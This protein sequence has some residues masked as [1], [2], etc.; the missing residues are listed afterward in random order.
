MN[1]LTGQVLNNTLAIGDTDDQIWLPSRNLTSL[2]GSDLQDQILQVRTS[3]SNTIATVAKISDDNTPLQVSGVSATESPFRTADG[4]LKSNVGVSFI[5]NPSDTFF[6]HVQIWFTGY[7]GNALPQL[8]PGDTRVSPASFLCDTTHETVTVTVVAVSSTGDTADFDTAPTT[9]VVLDGVTSAPSAPSIAQSLVATPTGY[10]FSFNQLGGLSADQVDGYQVWRNT[11]NNSSTAARFQYFK[12][13]PINSTPV[14]VTDVAP[15]G[16]VY[17]YWVSSVNTTG[18]ESSKTAVQSQQVGSGSVIGPDGNPHV[19]TGNLVYNPNFAIY[20][21]PTGLIDPFASSAR[22]DEID[23]SGNPEPS[24]NGWT[25]NFESSGNGEG[26]C[27]RIQQSTFFGAGSWSLV[28]Q[29]RQSSVNDCFASVSDAFP[30]IPGKKYRF[31][32]QVN[33]G[34][35][36][37][38]P[39]H[40]RWYFRVVFYKNL[41]TDFS[42]T[43]T[44]ISALTP[45]GIG[46]GAGF[47]SGGFTG[48]YDIA[49]GSALSGNQSPADTVTVPTDAA[50]ARI[51]FYHWNDGTATASVW[52][53]V[54]AAVQC[55]ALTV[56][57]DAAFNVSTVLNGQGSILPNQTITFTKAAETTSTLGWSWG[58]QTFLRPDSSTFTLGSGSQGFTGL[59]SNH[60]YFFYPYLTNFQT[61]TASMNF[62]MS[63]S[64]DTTQAQNAQFDGRIGMGVISDSTTATGTGGGGS[65]DPGGAC[66]HQDE[67]VWVGEGTEIPAKD[68]RDSHYIKGYS[69]AQKKDVYRR[70]VTIRHQP[71]TFWYRVNGHLVSPCEVVWWDNAWVPAY[72]VPGAERVRGVPADRIEIRVEADEFDER[73]YYL[74]GEKPLLIHNFIIERS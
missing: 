23:S 59:T 48:G 38:F 44:T 25:R 46:A 30:V 61:G 74:A 51:A 27:Y 33:A 71:S 42:R 5:A 69:F 17:F 58:T 3:I 52:N 64:A 66:P 35:G 18:L 34:L 16:T 22:T 53:L 56:D 32:A 63:A 57:G 21:T 10:Q 11:T 72:R 19:W 2:T 20:A 36:S 1:P 39:T 73:N 14:V 9:T 4:S 50:Y 12:H 55:Y 28:L 41:T 29:D 31:S 26:V 24:V 65:S 13:N 45:T 43:S 70:V 68:I 67:P 40:A 37:G 15:N 8:M 54:V 62:I 60:T 6:D 49:N 7:N 47:N